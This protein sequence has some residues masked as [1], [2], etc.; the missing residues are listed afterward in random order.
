MEM[1]SREQRII[2]AAGGEYLGAQDGFAWYNE[3]VSHSTMLIETAF[4]NA[5]TDETATLYLRLR[6]G[7]KARAFEREKNPQIAQGAAR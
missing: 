1:K 5:A 4:L 2:E 3:P 7:V 6:M